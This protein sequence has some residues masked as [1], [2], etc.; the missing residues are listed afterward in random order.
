MCWEWRKR[1]W[2]RQAHRPGVGDAR[3]G[4]LSTPARIPST[5]RRLAL[6]H[7]L[8]FTLIELLVVIAVI[9]LLMAILLPA[10]QHVRKQARAVTCRANLRQ[11]G[12]VFAAYAQE[13][14]GRLPTEMPDAVWLLRGSM[15]TDND[16]NGPVLRY[17]VGTEGI[18]LCPEAARPGQIDGFEGW[19]LPG[20]PHVSHVKGKAGSVSEAW[21]VITPGPAFR[22]SYGYNYWF[23]HPELPRPPSEPTKP[24]P[25]LFTIRPRADYPLLLDCTVPCSDPDP[26]VPPPPREDFLTPTIGCF[27]I[28]RH[29][30]R[31]N[32]LFAD[33]SV[34]PVGLKE[35]W[36]LRWSPDFDTAGRWTLAGGVKPEDWPQWMRGFKDY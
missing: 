32:G 13:N 36:T 20:E 7:A 15:P 14:Q 4:S 25:D 26:R 10:L 35:L 5:V 18:A 34:R 11:W 1:I 21:Q 17:P 31:I 33:M 19:T 8:G 22:C 2:D 3:A 30:A 16:P 29:D 9:A 24:R 27:C 12:V 23:I 6:G 28:N